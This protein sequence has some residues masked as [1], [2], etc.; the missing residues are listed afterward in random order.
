LPAPHLQLP[1]ESITLSCSGSGSFP[2][3]SESHTHTERL[4][5]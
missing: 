5:P 4:K 2:P 3:G 1:G